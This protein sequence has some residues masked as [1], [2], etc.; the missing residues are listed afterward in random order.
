MK[1][2]IGLLIATLLVASTAA[3]AGCE[4][5]GGNSSSEETSTGEI[6]G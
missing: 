4:M 6:Y 2:R 3:F 5:L 1:K